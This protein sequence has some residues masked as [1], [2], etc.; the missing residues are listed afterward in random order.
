MKK[1]ILK[2]ISYLPIFV[3]L[4]TIILIAGCCSKSLELTDYEVVMDIAKEK[5]GKNYFIEK[6]R[7]GTCYLVYRADENKSKLHTQLHY[8]VYENT[9][10]K[11]VY[12]EK[13]ID[14]SVKW[15]DEDNIE[16][17]FTPEIISGDEDENVYILNVITKEKQRKNFSN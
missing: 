14:A 7:S 17:I 5:L 8:F 2:S 3:Y 12:E 16:I 10:K 1:N 6:N 11:I 15:F 9:T 4:A 13:L